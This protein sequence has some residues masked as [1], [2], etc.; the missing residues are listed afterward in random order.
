MSKAFLFLIALCGLAWE[1][2]EAGEVKIAVAANFAVPLGRISEAFS[3]ETGHKLVVSSGATGKFYSQIREGAPFEILLS[4]DQEHPKKLVAEN[5]AVAGSQ[6]TYA[7]GKLA[8]WSSKDD[9]VDSKGEV[10][11]SNSFKHLAIANPKLAP[12]GAAAQEVLENKGLWKSIKPK[13]VYGEN[14][15]QTHQFVST[16]NAELGFVAFSQIQSAKGIK[17]SYWLIPQTL[18][19][20]IKQDAV[21]LAKGRSN[22]VAKQFLEFLKSKTAKSIIS[23]FGY[24]QMS[25]Q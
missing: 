1:Y 12:Y 25:A 5:L 16:G 3:K 22:P 15:A 14:I 6:F 17:G 18:Y 8:L 23:E 4:A 13:L 21:L 19:T 20:P 9:F 24:D 7:I 2:G 10:L 11:K